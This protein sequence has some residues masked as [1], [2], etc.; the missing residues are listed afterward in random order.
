MEILESLTDQIGYLDMAADLAEYG[1]G[2][3]YP[4]PM[5]GAIV[6]K[7]DLILGT[8]YHVRVGSAHAEIRAL[9]EAGERARGATLYVTIEPCCH[10]GRTPPC[11]EAIIAAGIKSVV[12]GIIDPNPL[13]SGGGIERLRESGLKVTVV[14]FNRI[15][16]Q[17]EV[18]FKYIQEKK[19]F[20]TLKI[21]TS[22]DGLITAEKGTKT[23]ITGSKAQAEVHK[24]RDECQAVMVG[25]GTVLVD[26]PL[27]TSRLE[28]E[29]ARQPIRVIVD[30]RG[31]LPMDSRIVLTAEQN[32]VILATTKKATKKKR[33][34]LEEHG[35][36]VLI[37]PQNERGKV[38]ID[39][40]YNMLGER[41]IANVLVEG[42]AR[43]NEE[44][45]TSELIDKLIWF[46]T[47]VIIGGKKS[48][49]AIK[50][51]E[52]LWQRFQIRTNRFLDNDLMI[53]MYPRKTDAQLSS[54][55]DQ[56]ESDN[57]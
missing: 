50:T 22:L 49:P 6:V 19:P 57:V 52:A 11:T 48:L 32:P 30:S 21:A 25:I 10:R 38:N 40:L 1:R 56:K 26:D 46:L 51:K 14:G 34:E 13:V 33:K 53:E 31:R 7:R 45:L 2:A 12:V 43:L 23:T 35:V 36:E 29:D 39:E 9:D 28:G 27:L 17:N 16:R 20:V 5:V 24:L 54:V 47:P 55:P 3:T 44:L 4:N 37:C 8:G 42:G 41:E 18:Y 15:I